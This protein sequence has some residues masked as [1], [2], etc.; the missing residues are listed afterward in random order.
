VKV[1]IVK[2]RQENV[3]FVIKKVIMHEFAQMTKIKFA[4]FAVH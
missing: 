4:E 3:E 2:V 1:K